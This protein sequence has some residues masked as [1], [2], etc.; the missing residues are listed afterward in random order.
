MPWPTKTA[1]A[2]NLAQTPSAARWRPRSRPASG[3]V[4]VPVLPAA[5][6]C[7]VGLWLD[8]DQRH[9]LEVGAVVAGGLGADQRELRGEVLGGQLAAARADA[10]PFQQIARQELDVSADPVSGDLLH[11]SRRG[12][13]GGQQN[14]S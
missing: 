3:N 1:S 11:L 8:A 12:R 6:S 7:A 14:Q 13:T 9:I 4:T 2:S 5:D 10:A